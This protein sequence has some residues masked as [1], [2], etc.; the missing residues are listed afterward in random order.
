MAGIGFRLNKILSKKSFEGLLAAYGYAAVIGSGPW[1]VSIGTLA[2]LGAMLPG[3]GSQDVAASA[4]FSSVTYAVALSLI[5]SGGLQMVLTRHVADLDYDKKKQE[6]LGATLSCLGIVIPLSAMLGTYFFVVMAPELPLL[7]RYSAA[8]LLTVFSGI[9]CISVYLTAMNRFEYILISY[10]IGY[11]V[12]F[13]SA[14]L[15]APHAAYAGA[16]VGFLMGQMLLFILLVCGVRRE[17]P[18]S[19]RCHLDYFHS[20]RK[21]WRLLLCGSLY[22]LALWID[23][24]IYWGID[25]DRVHLAGLMYSSTVYDKANYLSMLTMIPGLAAFLLRLE[26]DFSASCSEFFHRVVNHA[27]LSDIQEAKRLMIRAFLTG[28]WEMIRI[29]G[30]FTL[31]ILLAGEEARVFLGLGHLQQG[32]FVTLM[33]A[34]CVLVVLIGYTT[35][36]FYLDKQRD[37][38]ITYL[39]ILV[40]NTAGTAYTVHLGEGTYG[41]GLLTGLCVGLVYAGYRSSVTLR[42]LEFE[43]FTSQPIYNEN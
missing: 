21:Y 10:A 7:A 2:L 18:G 11:G 17:L 16:Y 35:L 26:T 29:Q 15:L 39:L 22:N 6:Q 14:W 32:V 13:L 23:K 37:V 8:M 36:L 31:L 28:L 43:T 40:T 41:L 27:T 30:V 24:F 3:F 4:F 33:L 25:P 1:L 19:A 20:I 9:W 12:S 5:L 38:L 34:A 42:L